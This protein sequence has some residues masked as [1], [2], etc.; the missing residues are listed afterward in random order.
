MFGFDPRV[1]Q[2]G[3]IACYNH[4][5]KDGKHYCA[6]GKKDISDLHNCPIGGESYN[7]DKALDHFRKIRSD[8]SEE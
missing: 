7:L 5:K 1:N 3:C 2:W 4:K 6:L 8:R